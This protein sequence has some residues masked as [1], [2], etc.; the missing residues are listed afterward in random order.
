MTIHKKVD[1]VTVGAGWTGGILAQQLT[2]HGLEV[3]SIERGPCQWAYPDFQHNRD[4]LRYSVRYAMMQD[5]GKETWTWRPN[6]QAP[7]LPM[8]QYGSFHPG[9]GLGG[10]GVHWAAQSWR[11]LPFDFRYRSHHVER[12]GAGKLPAGSTIQDWPLSYDELEPAYDAW[13]YDTGV[14][15]NAG[16]L[17]GARQAGGNIFEGP[18][19]RALGYHPFPQPAS[20]LSQ[21]YRDLSGRTRA[22]CMYCGYC[23]RFG[24]HV[25]AKSSA[26]TAHIPLALESRRYTV[27]A[28]STVIGI[29]VADNGL[30]TGVTFIDAAGRQH[31]QP[32]DIVVLSAFTLSNVRLLL[33]SKSDQHPGGVGNN[34]GM[35][36]KNYTYQISKAPVTGLFAGRRFNQ[37]MGNGCVLNVIY[38]L[39][40]DN[41]DHSNLDFIGG[42]RIQCGGGERDPLTSVDDVPFDNGAGDNGAEG[43]D[44]GGAT[45]MALCR[46]AS[47]ATACRIK[48]SSLILIRPTKTTSDCRCFA[49]PSTFTKTSIT[50]TV[51]S[52]RAAAR[53]WSV[54]NQTRSTAHRNSNPTTSTS[55]KARTIPAAQSWAATLATR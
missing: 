37:F 42:A 41:F 48:T 54:W 2:A 21:A 34:R 3:V 43:D 44:T 49:S 28:N 50:F 19:A 32:A 27:R 14:S 29:N 15:G 46:S 13:E 47:K 53:S 5:I 45:G 10:A 40:G 31:E 33:L 4:H 36:G 25:D 17:G 26:L 38:D 9:A 22:G 6:P 20:I 30:A 18:R 39:Y 55:T 8:R 12:Y 35:V 23:T 1:V 52:P 24:C 11:F 16:N 51:L 7:T